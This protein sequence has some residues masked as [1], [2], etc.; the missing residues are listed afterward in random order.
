MDFSL[1]MFVC[2]QCTTSP[3]A[4]HEVVTNEDAE[5]VRGSKD[6]MERF[7]RQTMFIREGL[8]KSEAMVLPAFD[9]AHWVKVNVPDPAAGKAGGAAGST[10]GGGLRIA[11][12]GSNEQNAEK[13][14]IVMSVDK[15]EE[16][17][18]REREQEAEAKRAQN[19]LPSWH[20]QSTISGDLTA[21]GIKQAAREGDGANGGGASL[22]SSI[23]GGLGKMRGPTPVKAGPDLQIAEDVKPVLNNGAD[24]YDAYYASL[25]A[26]QSHTNTMQN[27][28]MIDSPNS[29]FEDA[30]DKKPSVE[31]L[32][33]MA[34][35]L[36]STPGSGK[37]SRSRSLDEYTLSERDLKRSHIDLGLN[38]HGSGASETVV[39]ASASMDAEFGEDPIV[40]VGGQP[41]PF[42]QV[43]Q[44]IADEKMTP[45]EYTAWYELMMQQMQ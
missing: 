27:T 19:A 45:E 37:R 8:K 10:P 26:S 41:F 14:G 20:L 28:P 36:A 22:N 35:S 3:G 29:D 18:K 15:D 6:R 42:S 43:T 17:R 1:G 40:Y 39:E 7:N 11:G 13:I 2:D 16:T 12:S 32:D 25:E 30:E 24:Y 44:E 23:L 5:N 9:V 4:P 34:A 21:L 33:S 31:Y 38:G